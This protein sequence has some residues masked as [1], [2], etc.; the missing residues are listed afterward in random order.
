[1]Q[2]IN[3]LKRVLGDLDFV[4]WDRYV[5]KGSYGYV[6]YGWIARADGKFD[7]IQIEYNDGEFTSTTSSVIYTEKIPEIIWGKGEYVHNPCIRVES[8]FPDLDN[9]I[10]IKNA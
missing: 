5:E 6:L 1:M 2:N 9:V 4:M 8:L 3:E 10:H 7:Y